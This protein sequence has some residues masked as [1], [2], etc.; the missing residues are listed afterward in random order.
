MFL[1]NNAQ[2]AEIWR[3]RSKQMHVVMCGGRRI[4]TTQGLRWVETKLTDRQ[5]DRHSDWRRV[6]LRVFFIMVVTDAG[7]AADVFVVGV[8][9]ESSLNHHTTILEL[10][11]AGND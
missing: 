7:E 8:A 3:R 5:T 1:Q 6:K 11:L 9:T 2:T 4:R 10:V